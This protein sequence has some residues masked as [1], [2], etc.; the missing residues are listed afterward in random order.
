MAAA[1]VSTRL[2]PN[3][4]GIAIEVVFFPVRYHSHAL[5]FC[6]R[7]YRPASI[8]FYSD[9]V[10][11]A[12]FLQMIVAQV[13]FKVHHLRFY[14]ELLYCICTSATVYTVITTVIFSISQFSV[15]KRLQ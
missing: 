9:D 13:V 15:L 8:F 12:G 11:Q 1:S 3:P 14:P 7:G 4:F 5:I 2:Y 10:L 6:G